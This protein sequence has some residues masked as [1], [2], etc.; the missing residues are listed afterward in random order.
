[1]AESLGFIRNLFGT[2]LAAEA[3]RH[4]A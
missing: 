3:R 2:F 1:L 4:R